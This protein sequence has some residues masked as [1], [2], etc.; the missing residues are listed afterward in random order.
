MRGRETEG[1]RE[2][3]GESERERARKR[4][5]KSARESESVSERERHTPW[6]PGPLKPESGGGASPSFGTL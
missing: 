6:T 1:K 2:R 3:L 4:T 5:R